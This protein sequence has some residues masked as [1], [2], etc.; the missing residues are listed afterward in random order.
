MNLFFSILLFAIAFGGG[1]YIV[2]TTDE[3]SEKFT[4]SF[5]L[6]F[7]AMGVIITIWGILLHLNDT[8]LYSTGLGPVQGWQV[9]ISGILLALVAGVNAVKKI[10]K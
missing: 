1:L 9:T 5:L 8:F 3:E 7:T 6:L 4:M 10:K 2:G